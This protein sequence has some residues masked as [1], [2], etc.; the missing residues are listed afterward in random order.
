M[1]FD[2]FGCAVERSMNST[3]SQVSLWR[4]FL[5]ILWPSKI[6]RNCDTQML[7]FF[8]FPYKF[9]IQKIRCSRYF[10]S[11][12][13]KM[14]NLVMLKGN[15]VSHRPVIDFIEILLKSNHDICWIFDTKHSVLDHH[16]H[17]SPTDGASQIINKP[18]GM[19]T[20]C[21]L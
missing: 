12:N 11:D 8:H 2:L 5:T 3:K 13:R 15:L 1:V 6:I 4:N 20:S 17:W 16:D 9:T 21:V 10:L 14:K 7:V 18:M 19:C